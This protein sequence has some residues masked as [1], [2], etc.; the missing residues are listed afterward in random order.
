VKTLSNDALAILSSEVAVDGCE[1]RL[2]GGQLDR[3]LYVEVNAALEAIGGKWNRSKKAHI[4]AGSSSPVDA[5]DE[6]LVDGG[7]HDKKRDLEQFFTPLALAKDVVKKADV[8]G[9]TVL[10]PSAG[11][12]ALALEAV[13]HEARAV[14]CFEIDPGSEK[15]L[16]GLFKNVPNRCKVSV[17]PA[18]FMALNLGDM[19]WDR[20][21]MNPPFSKQQDITHVTRAY[22]LLAPKGRLVAIMAAG[23]KSRDNTAAKTFRDLVSSCG[24]V[25]DLPDGSFK[26]SGTD[27]RTILV[28][29]EN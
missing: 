26:E 14:T 12:G 24:K 22:G 11:L 17:A 23:T 25:E 3:K 19:R 4:F 18:D 27:V 16:K 2:T 20:V 28:T 15:I 21:V 1:V 6:I 8:A 7:F 13:R 29:L 5:L 9:K 10:E